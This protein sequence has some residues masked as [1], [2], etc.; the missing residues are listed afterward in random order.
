VTVFAL[1]LVVVVVVVVAVVIIVVV[2][3]VVVVIVVVACS[4][5]LF[6]GILL[7]FTPQDRLHRPASSVPVLLRAAWS[8]AMV[9]SIG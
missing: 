7:V 8:P 6:H 3:V 2:V 1:L 5:N 9:A 4:F